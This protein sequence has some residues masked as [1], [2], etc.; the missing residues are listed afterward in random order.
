MTRARVQDLHTYEKPTKDFCNLEKAR[1]IEKTIKKITL[2][3]GT[4]LT[5]QKSILQEIRNFYANLFQEKETNKVN[6]QNSDLDLNQEK[7]SPEE[8]L[9]AEG[10]LTVTELGSALKDMKHNKTPGIDGFPAEF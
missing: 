5:S 1:Y 9:S 6:W 10:L 4:K 7:L 8:A 3:N 2:K